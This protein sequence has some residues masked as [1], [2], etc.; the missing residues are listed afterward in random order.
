MEEGRAHGWRR[1]PARLR[2][3]WTAARSRRAAAS[4]AVG[5]ALGGVLGP[6]FGDETEA[7]GCPPCRRKKR[8]ACKKKKPNGT[9]CGACRACRGGRCVARCDGDACCGSNEGCDG[10]LLACHEGGYSQGYAPVCTWA[11][12]EG[13][14]GIRTPHEDPYE[15]WLGG[16]PC[17]TD[18]GPA[19]ATIER[20]AAQPG[21]GG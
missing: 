15:P 20:I 7:K 4:V 11:V 17:A 12:V 16:M 2:H 19:A 6:P 9:P 21:L 10:R 5:L 13:L 8:G 3:I 1:S 14:S 18:A